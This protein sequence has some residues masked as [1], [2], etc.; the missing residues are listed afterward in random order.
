MNH[1]IVYFSGTT[2]GKKLLRYLCLQNQRKSVVARP[3]KFVYTIPFD[4]PNTTT[5]ENVDGELV[6]SKKHCN[7]TDYSRQT[8]V[9]NGY[10]L[11]NLDDRI[12]SDFSCDQIYDLFLEHTDAFVWIFQANGLDNVP[13]LLSKPYFKHCDFVI[14][15]RK[16]GLVR[17][18]IHVLRDE[19]NESKSYEDVVAGLD[20]YYGNVGDRIKALE[21]A[22]I[23]YRFVDISD[24]D[25]YKKLGLVED[26]EY[27]F[28]RRTFVTGDP[29]F[30]DL[31]DTNEDARRIVDQANQYVI[32]RKDYLTSL[33]PDIVL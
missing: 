26:L 5:L 13:R 23:P 28:D 10:A 4:N 29:K 22:N 11:E 31:Y 7:F 15:Y 3:N 27:D 16:Y 18:M 30:E 2:C 1:P 32:D 8:K 19:C 6:E 14:P 33:F 21:D 17:Q 9:V 25:V 24:K 20:N 12:R